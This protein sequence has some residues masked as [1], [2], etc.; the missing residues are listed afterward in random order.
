MNISYTK[1][2]GQFT[3][4]RDKAA[5]TSRLFDMNVPGSTPI[6]QRSV[7][8][9]AGCGRLDSNAAVVHN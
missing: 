6:L 9:I 5:K 7:A 8:A 1:Q 2:R 4:N 3:R